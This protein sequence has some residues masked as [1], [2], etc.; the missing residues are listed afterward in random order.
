MIILLGESC[1]G[2][3]TI[4]NSLVKKFGYKRIVAYTTR[5]ARANEQEGIDYHFI[6]KAGFLQ[7]KE[8]GFFA[9]TAEYNGWYYGTAVEDCVDGTVAV[10]TPRGFRQLVKTN[11]I[12]KKSFYIK[13][14]RRHRLIKL[15]QRGDNIEEAYRRNLSDVGMFDGL[16]DEV[17]FVIRN[18]G[19]SNSADDI[20]KL[21]NELY[22]GKGDTR[23]GLS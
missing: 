1:A 18:P 11:E 8:E 22:L 13:V 12:P 17:D 5:T 20:A 19:Y 15:L 6:N 10:L 7:L 4:A 16:E 21:I 2:K 9:E 14:P 3:S 23:L